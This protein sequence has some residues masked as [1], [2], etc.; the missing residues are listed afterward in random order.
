MAAIF[1]CH[2]SRTV[3][4][5]ACQHP[6]PWVVCAGGLGS[7]YAGIR[8]TLIRAFPANAAQWLAWEVAMRCV[9]HTMQSTKLHLSWGFIRVPVLQDGQLPLHRLGATIP[10]ELNQL[11]STANVSIEVSCVAVSALYA[12]CRAYHKAERGK[13]S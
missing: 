3:R 11:L 12:Q 6:Q 4:K 5:E 10:Q 2:V 9:Q 7:L 13:P 8:P 1:M